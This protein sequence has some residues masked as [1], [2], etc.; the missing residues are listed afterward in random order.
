M[1]RKDEVKANVV[2]ETENLLVF[3]A[4]RPLDEAQFKLLSKLVREEEEKSGVKIV[5]VPNSVDIVDYKD[6]VGYA[7]D[8]EGEQVNLQPREAV[9]PLNK[10]KTI[11]LE[12]TVEEVNSQITAEIGEDGLKDL[13]KAEQEGKNRKGVTEHIQTLL[14]TEG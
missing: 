6:L 10:N 5:L 4:N 14:N 7:G 13:L 12:G 3:K 2:K 9:L 8:P 1:A 11:T